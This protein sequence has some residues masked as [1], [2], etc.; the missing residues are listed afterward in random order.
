MPP[1]QPLRALSSFP[2]PRRHHTHPPATPNRLRLY[3]RPPTIR[4]AL[5]P[6]C[7]VRS[8]K[9]S[10]TLGPF[11]TGPMISTCPGRG[12][13]IIH[14]EFETPCDGNQPT[15]RHLPLVNSPC[16]A[17]VRVRSSYLLDFSAFPSSRK[18]STI[19]DWRVTSTMAHMSVLFLVCNSPQ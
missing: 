3:F 17:A 1:P 12:Q 14:W 8:R 6:G 19:L 16:P 4:N 10:E 15:C 9:P 13:D 18:Y 5:R 11:A 7:K 2:L